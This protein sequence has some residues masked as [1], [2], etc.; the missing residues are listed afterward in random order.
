MQ[1]PEPEFISYDQLSILNTSE[2]DA[3]IMLVVF[4]KIKNR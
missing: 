3:E 2:M 1:G 4:I